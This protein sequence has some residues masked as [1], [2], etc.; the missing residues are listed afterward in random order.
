MG[1]TK[2]KS[3]VYD[4][5]SETWR[6]PISYLMVVLQFQVVAEVALDSYI[7]LRLSCVLF[8]E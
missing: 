2:S 7:E 5:M 6:I 8:G 3:S 1:C 4:L